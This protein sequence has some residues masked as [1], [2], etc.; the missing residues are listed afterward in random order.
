MPVVY[1]ARPIADLIGVPYIPIPKHIVPVPKPEY[2]VIYGE[3]MYFEGSGNER[4]PV[5]QDYVNQ[6]KAKI[7]SLIET[8]RKQRDIRIQLA[9][10]QKENGLTDGGRLNNL[11]RSPSSVDTYHQKDSS[12]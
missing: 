11:K 9:Q 10:A 5:I 4:D 7:A 8:G 3:P 12:P 1:H 6:V 2:E